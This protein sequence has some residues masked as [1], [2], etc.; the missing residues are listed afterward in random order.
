MGLYKKL[1][2]E[3]VLV[4]NPSFPYL[5]AI[6]VCHR[7]EA[8]SDFSR[9]VIEVVLS[10]EGDTIY[11]V[12]SDENSTFEVAVFRISNPDIAVSK[13]AFISSSLSL[14]TV[15]EGVLCLKDGVP[16]LWD[17]DLTRCIRPLP[18]LRGA[19]ELSQVSKNLIACQQHCRKL[20][21]GELGSFS[22]SYAVT[23][24][25]ERPL[26]TA[27]DDCTVTDEVSGVDD[28]ADSSESDDATLLDLSRVSMIPNL[29][30]SSMF[31]QESVLSQSKHGLNIMT[32]YN[33]CP[34]IVRINFLSVLLMK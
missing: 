15:K 5:A 8:H 1:R 28:S 7:D 26:L 18:K 32:K 34:A 19:K 6:N 4:S 17:F 11:P 14:L 9:K 25:L 21:H 20:R 24:T 27:T 12:T 30:T 16:E 13:P 29:W 22:Q 33:S 10:R 23:D 3:T 2:R 31:P